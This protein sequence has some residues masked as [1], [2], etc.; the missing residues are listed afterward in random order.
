M[1][2]VC[3]CLWRPAWWLDWGQVSVLLHCCST[4]F[5]GVPSTD[6]WTCTWVAVKEN[7]THA[8]DSTTPAAQCS[9]NVYDVIVCHVTV[10]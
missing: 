6:S 5:F 3:H 1:L 8:L 9:L 7:Q 4:Y 2:P 10:G